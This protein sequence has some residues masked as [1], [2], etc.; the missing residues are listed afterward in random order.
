MPISAVASIIEN[1]NIPLDI[2]FPANTNSDIIITI[3]NSEI[4]SN[5]PIHQAAEKLSESNMSI[6]QINLILSHIQ[7]DKA[8]L[9]LSKI[10]IKHYNL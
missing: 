8:S 2:I 3:I 1:I 4:I 10:N 5:M 9:I 7:P 6:S